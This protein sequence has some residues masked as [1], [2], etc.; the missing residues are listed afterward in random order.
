LTAPKDTVFAEAGRY[1]INGVV[2]TGV[3]YAA[4]VFNL[5]ILEL[6][7]A[8]LA[9]L[10]AATVGIAASFLGSRYFVF[11][12]REENILRQAAKFGLLYATIALLHGVILYFW[13]DVGGFDYRVG[14][15][16][17]L[18]L[19]VVLSYWGNKTLVFK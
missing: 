15:L 18:V 12:R 16:I 9:N 14:F 6:R 1:V 5:H 11:R 2:A 8:G 7:S 4:L 17:A 19:Q 13:T 10:C 3:H